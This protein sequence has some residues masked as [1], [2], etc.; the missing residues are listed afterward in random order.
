MTLF[1]FGANLSKKR[2]SFFNS[3][4]HI[5][6]MN[7]QKS[8]PITVLLSFMIKK[9]AESIKRN[10]LIPVLIHLLMSQ[11]VSSESYQSRDAQLTLPNLK[12]RPPPPPPDQND[13]PFVRVCGIWCNQLRIHLR[14]RV[15]NYVD[16][17]ALLGS[18]L[19][20]R[21]SPVCESTKYGT[22]SHTWQD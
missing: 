17:D 7:H 1:L 21:W 9:I 15:L 20:R 16:A 22:M 13:L 8:Q 19:L 10:V 18:Y 4:I 6:L 2:S 11:S 12:L 14:L 5:P 3:T